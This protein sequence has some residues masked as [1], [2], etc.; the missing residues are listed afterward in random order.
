MSIY[1][2]CIYIYLIIIPHIGYETI[3]QSRLNDTLIQCR[4]KKD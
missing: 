1:V 3:T 2:I 4:R